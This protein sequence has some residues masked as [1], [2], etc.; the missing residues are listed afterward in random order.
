M[1]CAGERA[2]EL[3]ADQAE[4]AAPHLHAAAGLG[5]A[6]LPQPSSS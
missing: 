4:G 5:D 1:E 6:D 2:L 3:G